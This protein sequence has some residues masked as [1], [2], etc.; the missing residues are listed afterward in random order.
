MSQNNDKAFDASH[1][2]T[3]GNS[4]QQW[5]SVKDEL[6]PLNEVILITDG[7][8]VVAGKRVNEDRLPYNFIE[9]DFDKLVDEDETS[10]NSFFA[11]AVTHWMP[12]PKPPTELQAD[13]V[14]DATEV[15]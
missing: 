15:K 4:I 8:G 12:L 6:P 14:C 7:D 11:G 5:I 9:D 1:S 3:F 2:S 10:Y 13:A